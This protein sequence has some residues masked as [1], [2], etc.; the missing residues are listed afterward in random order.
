MNQE[1]PIFV[2]G[3]RFSKIGKNYY[4]N[5]SHLNEIQLGDFIVVET[6]RGWQL[7]EVAEILHEIDPAMRQNLK[8]IDRR[9]TPVDLL[10]KQELNLKEDEALAKSLQK[11]RMMNIRGLKIVTAEYGFDEKSISI[12]FSSPED[13]EVKGLEKLQKALRDE[14][15]KMRIDFHKI[16]PRDVAKFYGGLGA[17]GLE[18][19]CCTR[20]LD[21]FQ[22]ISI[23][24][25]K[26]QDISLTPS[27]ITG[28][29]DRLRC[30]LNYEFSQYEEILQGLPKRNQRV[31]TPNGEGKVV[32]LI[33][34]QEKVVVEFGEEG[35]KTYDAK[36]IKKIEPGTIPKSSKPQIHPI[37]S[38]S[39]QKRNN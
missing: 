34:L 20:F 15:P 31:L 24:M 21:D 26:I 11:Q 32:D 33:P 5:A 30:C 14:F 1:V 18:T 23:K 6:S 16:G 3:V 27:D 22:S 37:N 39:P 36:D 12:L 9:A 25:A 7:G 17:C 28:M 2:V 8:K 10:K 19:R 38:S 13:E 4:F 35:E 29:C